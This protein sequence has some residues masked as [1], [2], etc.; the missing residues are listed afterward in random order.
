MIEGIELVNNNLKVRKEVRKELVSSQNSAKI[1]HKFDLNYFKVGYA[2]YV[3][4]FNE[5]YPTLYFCV[6]VN[7]KV[8]HLV[9][10]SEIEECL[11]KAEYVDIL[12]GQAVRENIIFT[13]AVPS[14]ISIKMND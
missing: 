12:V 13:V 9:K 1:K 4:K 10:P 2:Y 5:E 11:D 3:Q 8:I 7:E 14:D 6:G